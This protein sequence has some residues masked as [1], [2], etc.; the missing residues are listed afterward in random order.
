ML[1]LFTFLV[2]GLMFSSATLVQ[3]VQG[4]SIKK[5]SNRVIQLKKINE[6]TKLNVSDIENFIKD[7]WS[8]AYSRLQ[9]Q[10][11]I[12]EIEKALL[13][14]RLLAMDKSRYMKLKNLDAKQLKMNLESLVSKLELN[15]KSENKLSGIYENIKNII[16]LNNTLFNL[17]VFLIALAIVAACEGLAVG[18]IPQIFYLLPVIGGVF[19]GLY[20]TPLSTLYL[21]C[22]LLTVVGV[23][24]SIYN[25]GGLDG[26][27]FAAVFVVMELPV[28]IAS[29]FFLPTIVFVL[30]LHP[31]TTPTSIAFT[32]VLT[33]VAAYS[34]YKFFKKFITGR[35]SFSQLIVSSI[36]L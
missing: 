7:K 17:T 23:I 10:G 25:I 29:L 16:N 8:T 2:A 12:N 28:F 18:M 5:I 20:S 4:A 11:K 19:C 33:A 24:E 15:K 3:Q 34:L 31:I 14:L 13:K 21:T 30:L 1:L 32:S 35:T 9:S 27:I 26:L 22:F 36:A 6:K